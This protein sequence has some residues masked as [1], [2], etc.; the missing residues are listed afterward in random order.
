MHHF[1]QIHSLFLSVNMSRQ[2]KKFVCCC[3]TT[4]IRKEYY[5]AITMILWEPR[6]QDYY[7]CCVNLMEFS[8]KKNI[9]LHDLNWIQYIYHFKKRNEK[10]DFG[11]LVVG[12]LVGFT[13]YQLI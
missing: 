12:W 3:F 7:F 9:T 8:D 2:C 6:D 4:K 1:F 13:A 11:W 5:S 10:L